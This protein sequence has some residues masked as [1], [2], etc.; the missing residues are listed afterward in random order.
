MKRKIKNL[1]VKIQ[2]YCKSY[3]EKVIDVMFCC[4][5][6]V[7]AVIL[8]LIGFKGEEPKKIISSDIAY[9]KERIEKIS[10]NDFWESVE[11]INQLEKKGYDVKI[12]YENS[13]ITVSYVDEYSEEIVFSKNKNGFISYKVVNS[14]NVKN[15][16]VID[17]FV[18]G[19]IGVVIGPAVLIIIVLICGCIWCVVCYIIEWIQKIAVKIKK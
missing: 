3:E 16:Q 17:A 5:M 14:S 10:K 4:S 8:G 13:E 11:I 12:D 9:C 15:N 19:L 18:F 1:I 2:E 7:G 6:I